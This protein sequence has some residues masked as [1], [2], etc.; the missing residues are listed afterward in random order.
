MSKTCYKCKETKDYTF[1]CKNKNTKDGYNN[2]C[3]D[4]KKS[5]NLN[6]IER[7]RNYYYSN[8]ECKRVPLIDE[9]GNRRCYSCNDYKPLTY[10][11]KNKSEI[12]GINRLCKECKSKE[13]IV[14]KDYNSV[15]NF[16]NKEKYYDKQNTI[17]R[18]KYKN[19]P[20]Y[21]L[22]VLLKNRLTQTLK[23]Q[24]VYKTN[25]MIPLLGCNLEEAKLHLEYQFKPEWDW[26]N[27]GDLWE[28]DHILPCSSFDLS[29]PEQQKIC[30][31]YTNLQ[32]LF[33]TTEIAESFGYYNEI[34]NRDKSDNIL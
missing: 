1:F 18:E 6:N 34:G 8:Y 32:P 29:D 30:F 31:H 13:N 10:F 25:K 9:L 12:D 11:C 16:N 5:D 7:T 22:T 23:R 26:D 19:D 21:K 3:K 28:I 33:K 27:H 17:K 2:L 20:I 24:S 14:N 4:C 15:Y